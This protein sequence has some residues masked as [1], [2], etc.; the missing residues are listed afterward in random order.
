MAKN[1]LQKVPKSDFQSQFS[2]SKIL[3]IF[4]KK[5]LL[6]N[7]NLGAHFLF[8]SILRSMKLER[9]LFL[10]F[11]KNLAFLTAIFGHLASLIKKPM[12]FLWSVQSWLESEMFFIKFY[13]HREKITIWSS[14]KASLGYTTLY[15]RQNWT[16][17]RLLPTLTLLLLLLRCY[18][19]NRVCSSYLL[20]AY[21]QQSTSP[22][23]S[24]LGSR[25]PMGWFRPCLSRQSFI[26]KIMQIRQSILSSLIQI[27]R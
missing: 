19:C 12:S 27:G 6:K 4:I 7:I 20:W 15:V 5:F 13:W 16:R 8:S 21:R 25:S 2:M 1:R 24:Y 18:M 22:I 11:L 26:L 10:K 9:L 14:Y 17:I 3:Q 23:S